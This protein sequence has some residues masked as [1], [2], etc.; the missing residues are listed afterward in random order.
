MEVSL[1]GEQEGTVSYMNIESRK[2]VEVGGQDMVEKL[3]E[4]IRELELELQNQ[5][6]SAEKGEKLLKAMWGDDFYDDS[7]H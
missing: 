4:R 5:K 7:L 2:I 6:R 1:K 3:K